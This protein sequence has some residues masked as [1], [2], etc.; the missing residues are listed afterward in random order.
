MVAE[1]GPNGRR[2]LEDVRL[3]AP[4]ADPTKIVAAPVNYR[5]HQYSSKGSLQ[6]DPFVARWRC[7]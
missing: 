6:N 1:L 2:P 7:M 4:V 5:D 3:L